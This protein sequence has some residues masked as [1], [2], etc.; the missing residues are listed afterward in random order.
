MIIRKAKKE[1]VR[2]AEIKAIVFD[3]GEVLLAENNRKI[4]NNLVKKFNLDLDRFRKAKF[5]Y[6]DRSMIR[7]KEDFWFEKKIAKKLNV[8]INNFISSWQ[9]LMEENFEIKKDV[10]KIVKILGKKGY[11]L[12]SLTDVNYSHNLL[13]DKL[14][15]YTH[16]KANFKSI[17]LKARKPSQ[18]IYT[19]LLKK[20]N[21]LPQEIVFIDDFKINLEIPKKMG[22]KVILFKNSK[23]LKK[24]LNKLG[25]RI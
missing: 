21:Y 9:K 2:K 22:V 11:F 14:G 12:C 6:L 24:D 4:E 7:I 5:K 25:V 20:I 15:V 23:Q 10:L 18:R 19:L 17:E 8:D 1:E 16:F 13:R 3:I